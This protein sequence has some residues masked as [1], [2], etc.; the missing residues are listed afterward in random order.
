MRRHRLLYN[1][2]LCRCMVISLVNT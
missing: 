1:T 2:P